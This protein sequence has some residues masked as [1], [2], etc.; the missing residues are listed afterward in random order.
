MAHAPPGKLVLSFEIFRDGQLLR[1]EEIAAESV[2]I[3]RGAA[4]MLR[5]DCPEM[6][7]LHAVINVNDDGT[8]QLLDLGSAAGTQ[9]NGTAVANA[10]LRTGDAISVG[11]IR[12]DVTISEETGF[13]DDEATQLAMSPNVPA[14]DDTDHGGGA[15]EYA[16]MTEGAGAADEAA[17]VNHDLHEDVM[18]F[19][20]RSGA[21]GGDAGLDRSKPRVLEV[22][23]I[24]GEV[25]LDVQHFPRG[26]KPVSVGS[27]TGFRWRILGLPVAWVPAPFAKVA[28]LM[29]PTL[30]EAA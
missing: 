5:L 1:K 24:W 13:I 23:E 26:S 28:W 15:H 18:A 16:A 29:A 8:V 21:E 4:A 3:G 6:A 10:N 2:T 7:D 19:I 11:N 14:D 9:L 27:S 22:A 25:V 17:M 12:L 20:M 30:S